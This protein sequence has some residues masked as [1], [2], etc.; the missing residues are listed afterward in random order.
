MS[1]KSIMLLEMNLDRL[2]KDMKGGYA[3]KGYNSRHGKEATMLARGLAQ[4]LSQAIRLEKEKA[5]EA[6]NMGFDGRFEVIKEWFISLPAEQ[7]KDFF[8]GIAK[9]YNRAA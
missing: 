7:K 4:I 3:D 5:E 2:E 6:A 9:E 1:R 8:Q